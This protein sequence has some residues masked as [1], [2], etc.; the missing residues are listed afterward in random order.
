[1]QDIKL[2]MECPQCAGEGEFYTGGGPTQ[3]G[4]I[5]C[6]WP[7]CNGSGYIEAGTLPFDPGLDDVIDKCNDII[8][9]CNDILAEVS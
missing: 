4:P 8:D 3:T 6:N 7:G 5:P 2:F 9:K 1:M